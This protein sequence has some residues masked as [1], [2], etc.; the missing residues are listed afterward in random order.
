MVVHRCEFK[1]IEVQCS[2]RDA[3]LWRSKIWRLSSSIPPWNFNGPPA[4][5]KPHS[6]MKYI[7]S[8]FAII[9]LMLE[10]IFVSD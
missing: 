8:K 10:I 6:Y 4:P 1:H 5:P 3:N 9:I 7:L 2:W